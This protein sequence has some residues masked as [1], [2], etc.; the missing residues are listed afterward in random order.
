MKRTIRPLVL[1]A[2]AVA[3]LTLAA[4]SSGGANEASVVGTWG[5]PDAQGEPSLTFEEDGSYSGT[6]GCN[7]V[8]GE[9]NADGSTI[10]LGNMI[11]TMMYCEGV[12]TWLVN[13]GTA[14]LSGDTLTFSDRDGAEIGTLT[15]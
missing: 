12:D 8:G 6:D 13:A 14:E 10:D 3:A 15:R 9:W 1:A 11:S 2:A 5:T 4:C 7:R